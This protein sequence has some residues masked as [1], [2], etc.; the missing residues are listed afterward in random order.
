M[1]TLSVITLSYVDACNWNV[2]LFIRTQEGVLLCCEG[3]SL[4]I[5]LDIVCRFLIVAGVINHLIIFCYGFIQQS[6]FLF[7]VQYPSS[8]HIPYNI[9]NPLKQK[10][11]RP[12]DIAKVERYTNIVDLLQ[13]AMLNPPQMVSV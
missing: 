4:P 10:G 9:T 5:S 12:L 7:V 2:H 11:Q 13:S 3:R 1:L 8:A 6:Y